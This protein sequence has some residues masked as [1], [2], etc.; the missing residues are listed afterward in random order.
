MK[1]VKEW[2]GHVYFAGNF[3][4]VGV[5]VGGG[6][7]VNLETGTIFPTEEFMN[8]N[9]LG[10]ARIT[11]AV[12]DGVGG[13]FVSGNFQIANTK[14]RTYLAHFLSDGKLDPNFNVVINNVVNKV[15]IH[16]GVLYLLGDFTAVNGNTR[17]YLAAIDLTS[18]QVNS[19]NPNPDVQPSDIAFGDGVAFVVGGYFSSLGG[20][21]RQFVGAV[22]LVSGTATGWQPSIAGASVK[23]VSHSGG[24][25][26]IGGNFTSINSNT[27]NNLAAINASDGLT[28]S[29][30]PNVDGEV[31]KLLIR[32]EKAYF[33]GSFTL[34]G[35]STPRDFLARV[36][37]TGSGAPD[38][39]APA[40]SSY[41]LNPLEDVYE[42]NDSVFFVGNFDSVNGQSRASAAKVDSVFGTATDSWN[43]GLYDSGTNF[44]TKSILPWNNR[45][46]IGG[47]YVFTNIVDRNYL[48]S[49]DLNHQSITGFSPF[50]NGLI[51]D[52]TFHGNYLYASGNFTQ[53]GSSTRNGFVELDFGTAQPTSWN[54][55]FGASAGEVQ[56][57]AVKD[58]ALYVGGDLTT[59]DA[60]SIQRLA[61]IDLSGT[62][63]TLLWPNLNFD[64]SVRKLV[65]SETELFVAGTFTSVSGNARAGMVCLSLTGANVT[66][67]YPNFTDPITTPNNIPI[68]TTAGLGTI[69]TF[70][71]FGGA[72]YSAGEFSSVNGQSRYLVAGFDLEQ[73]QLLPFNM[74]V[75]GSSVY[76][77][78]D[79]GNS[80][81]L[82][83]L[84]QYD[85]N[86]NFQ[87]ALAKI[88]K[89]GAV[90]RSFSQ[91]QSGNLS[92]FSMIRGVPIVV[93][94]FYKWNQSFTQGIWAVQ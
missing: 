7:L 84:S 85:L 60:S 46:F 61:K 91:L 64:G 79:D 18:G 13:I 66:N 35:G 37:L 21:I 44:A 19:W 83:S 59:V 88:D 6:S 8:F 55:T 34:V 73:K 68:G 42:T 54:P 16:A 86:L 38:N 51:N 50:F 33:G 15:T 5:P 25:V 48:F 11:S 12:L 2:N 32:G 53:V 28:T 74:T 31:T 56:T 87:T 72:L 27:R 81:Y 69:K 30:N 75:P 57:L 70:H 78:S 3:T 40:I 93:G 9:D 29:W 26:Y 36:S 76:G 14:P 63:R 39:W 67:F 82:L 1:V 49:V 23:T 24:V 58:N 90:D 41:S 43:P 71:I 80:L 65:F 77:L 62:T 20:Q 4:K 10:A 94:S 92:S 52:I 45:L 89:T 47:N 22:D 17:N